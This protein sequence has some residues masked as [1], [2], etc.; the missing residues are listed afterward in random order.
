MTAARE[1]RWW[2]SGDGDVVARMSSWGDGVY[3]NRSPG[4]PP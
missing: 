3:E 4:Q 1:E 2:M